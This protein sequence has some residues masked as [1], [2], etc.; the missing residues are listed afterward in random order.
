METLAERLKAGLKASSM[1][2]SALA[3]K[4]G[5]KPQYIQAICSGRIKRPSNIVEIAHTLS[6]SPLWLQ[7]GKGAKEARI[8]PTLHEATFRIPIISW[9]D[10]GRTNIQ[11][12]KKRENIAWFNSPILLSQNAYALIMHGY[13]MVGKE[14]A[15]PPGY[16]ITVETE[17]QPK[18]NCYVIAMI[19]GGPA[20]RQYTAEG[21][22]V[23][24]R[25]LNEQYPN[26]ITLANS[27]TKVMGV[28][29][30]VFKNFD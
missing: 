7:T 21:G 25:I 22:Q 27:D 13:S 12:L 19:D 24:L 28:I 4:L 20:L 2:Q 23:F 11:E 18:D 6:L 29:K 1:T 26:Q 30:S 17:E 14:V 3:E 9:E 16:I 15:F 8:E 10:I 5:F